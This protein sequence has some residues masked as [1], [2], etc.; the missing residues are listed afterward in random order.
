MKASALSILAASAAFTLAAAPVVR[1]NSVTMS[2]SG[3]LVTI[4]YTLEGEA[5]I[6][7]VDIQTNGV[8]IGSE[9]LTF[10]AGDVNK[11][12]QP[13]N[14]TIIWKPYKAWPDHYSD[15]ARA[16]VSAWSTDAPPDYMV[17]SLVAT[18][19]VRYFA[20]AEEVPFGVTDDRY[21]TEYL[22][23]RKVPAA[24]VE[25][26]MGS[27][28]TEKWRESSR[29]APRLVTLSDDYYIGVY[30]VTQKQ[31]ALIYGSNPSTSTA[32]GDMKPV[33]NCWFNHLRG[34]AGSG[35]DWPNNGH[36]VSS[37]SF[38]G[39]LR[40]KTGVTGFD[41][42]TEAQWEFA[43]RAGCGAGLYSGKEDIGWDTDANVA[44][45]AVNGYNVLTST[46]TVGQKLP[47]A[48][49]LYDMLGNVEEWVLDWLAD[50]PAG[51][52]DPTGP[53]SGAQRVLRGGHYNDKAQNCRCASR[54]LMVPNW[55]AGVIGFRVACSLPTQQ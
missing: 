27:P 13:G 18:N 33:E 29:E 36:A 26:R 43:C 32:D 52:M 12:V 31:Y 53:I 42:P 55:S 44:E 40:A 49:G 22:L 37:D 34:A 1:E 45:L 8:S 14:R 15:N 17:V 51:G 30:E 20:T 9:N 23:L 25:W 47:N 38:F 10:F 28:S 35:Y 41:L 46:D 24:N 5:G 7:T 54:S 16:V 3:G 6:V 11:L 21:K 50:A 48:W 4:G 19:S 2:Q 39:K